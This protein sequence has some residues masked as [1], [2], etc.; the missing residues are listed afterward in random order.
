MNAGCILGTRPIATSKTALSPR[1]MLDQ[2]PQLIAEEI[3]QDHVGNDEELVVLPHP[4][5]QHPSH[6]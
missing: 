1:T 2:K 6:L 4:T 3:E 5:P